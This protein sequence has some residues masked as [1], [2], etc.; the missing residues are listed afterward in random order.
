MNHLRRRRLAER[1]VETAMDYPA[2]MD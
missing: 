2:W 1:P